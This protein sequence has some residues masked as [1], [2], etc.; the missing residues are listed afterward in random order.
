[1]STL[2][3]DEVRARTAAALQG[4]VLTTGTAGTLHEAPC[5]YDAMPAGVPAQRQHLAFGVAVPSTTE[6]PD[7][8]QRQGRPLR[9]STALRVRLLHKQR[10][11]D[12]VADMDAALAA[13]SEVIVAVLGV[14]GTG[15]LEVTYD[16]TAER[17][18][19]PPS[20]EVPGAI[21]LQLDFTATHRI[22]TT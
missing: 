13:E 11:T 16:G 19:I 6:A 2:R 1:M 12:A 8:K 17:R 15:G 21:L 3:P 10:T 9:V 18:P 14:A 4:L 22:A 20:Q 7:Q 5:D